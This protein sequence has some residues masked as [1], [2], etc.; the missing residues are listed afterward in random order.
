MRVNGVMQLILIAFFMCKR[1]VQDG[2]VG[3]E[4][5]QLILK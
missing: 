5:V 3:V 2:H 1:T 4:Q